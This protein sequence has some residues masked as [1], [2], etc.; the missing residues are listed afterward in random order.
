MTK[1]LS[2]E[3][4]LIL[5]SEVVDATGGMHGVRDIALLA[6]IVDKPKASFGG[7]DL[8]PDVFIKAAVCLESIVNYHVF[9]DGNK[10]TG[11][12]ACARFL[13]QNGYTLFATNKEVEKFVLSIATDT[14]DVLVIAAWLKK[15]TA[16]IRTVKPHGKGKK[17]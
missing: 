11:I 3:T 7:R 17:R 14:T 9:I 12:T 13:Y 8:Y 4:I 15:H 16:K 5:H 6:A 1:Y 10:R 2:A